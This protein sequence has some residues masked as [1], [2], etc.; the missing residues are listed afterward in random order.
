[1]VVFVNSKADGTCTAETIRDAMCGSLKHNLAL[2]ESTEQILLKFM[3]ESTRK[4][5]KCPCLDGY[6]VIHSEMTVGAWYE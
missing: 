2:S 5:C 1:V 4:V 6:L 3:T